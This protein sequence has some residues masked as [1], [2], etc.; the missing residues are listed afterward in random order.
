MKL[1]TM[2]LGGMTMLNPLD[3]LTQRDSKFVKENFGTDFKWRVATASH[4]IEGGWS[5]YG[6]GESVW[7]I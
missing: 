5:I 3:L 4:Q 6:K 2:R 7:G 1:V